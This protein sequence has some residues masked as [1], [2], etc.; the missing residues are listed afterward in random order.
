VPVEGA[1]RSESDA[2]G[3]DEY[4]CYY[5]EDEKSD[6][7]ETRKLQL[8]VAE[9][10][11]SLADDD[12]DT[13]EDENDGVDENCSDMQV[14]KSSRDIQRLE[15]EMSSSDLTCKERLAYGLSLVKIAQKEK[16]LGLKGQKK[17]AT[18]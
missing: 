17:C 6:T 11:L 2:F 4:Y 16:E 3:E 13:T 14:S 15:R 18:S 5:Y 9:M 1:S 12:S 8:A 10:S 7:R